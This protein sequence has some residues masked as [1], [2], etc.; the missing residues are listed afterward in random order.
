MKNVSGNYANKEG[1]PKLG[2]EKI[3]WKI[4]VDNIKT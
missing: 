3:K 1:G 4:T 2:I